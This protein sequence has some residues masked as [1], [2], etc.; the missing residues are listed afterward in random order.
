MGGD[1]SHLNAHL[2]DGSQFTDANGGIVTCAT[3]FLGTVMRQWRAVIWKP[4]Q[5]PKRACATY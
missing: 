1:I 2:F 3:F 5:I 4:R